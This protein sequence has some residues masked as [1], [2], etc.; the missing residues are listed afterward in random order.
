M[1]AKRQPR[2]VWSHGI[3]GYGEPDG[4]TRPLTI[5]PPAK[6]RDRYGVSA[7]GRMTT[8][9]IDLDSVTIT[10]R[11]TGAS[12]TF[13]VG[14]GARSAT[15]VLPLDLSPREVGILWTAARYLA[16]WA[17]SNA[18]RP[19]G[20]YGPEIAAYAEAVDR[21]IRASEATDLGI[22]CGFEG[23]SV[24]QVRRHLKAEGRGPWR[25]FV[26]ARRAALGL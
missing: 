14:P 6:Y 9:S 20:N 12:L 3:G 24:R 19:V 4:T 7:V 26:A 10:D 23:W 1:T 13:P 21:R 11:N 2:P 15:A 18:G 8:K 16:G 17:T 5:M 25:T 22:V